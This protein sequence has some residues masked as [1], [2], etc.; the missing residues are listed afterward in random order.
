LKGKGLAKCL[1][2]FDDPAHWRGRAHEARIIADQMK[3]QKPSLRCW[4]S[5][6]YELLAEGAERRNKSKPKES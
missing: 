4:T 1:S 6:G 2:I 5:P 3:D